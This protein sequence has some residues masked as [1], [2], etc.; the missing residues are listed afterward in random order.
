MQRINLSDAQTR[1]R[2]RVAALL[3][4][5]KTAAAAE[6]GLQLDKEVR[7]ATRRYTVRPNDKL[8][9][10]AQHVFGNAELW[11][12]IWHANSAQI[13]NPAILPYGSTLTIPL[14]PTSLEAAEAIAEAQH[15]GA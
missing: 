9:A 5:G 8:G 10:I 3:R 13:K 1:R 2:D 15:G 4:A 7:N 11:P 14:H 12:L 6:L